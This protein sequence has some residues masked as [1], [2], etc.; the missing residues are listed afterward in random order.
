MSDKLIICIKISGDE[1]Y[2]NGLPHSPPSNG[3]EPIPFPRHGNATAPDVAVAERTPD[4]S[5]ATQL[6]TTG[7]L[8]SFLLHVEKL[9]LL[10]LSLS[11]SS[12]CL[13]L[14]GMV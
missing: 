9:L 7:G 13:C 3:S 11:I 6:S 2:E 5:S 1:V 14:L 8:I 10:L 4:D 12:A